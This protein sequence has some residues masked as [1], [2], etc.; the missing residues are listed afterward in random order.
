[1]KK[2]ELRQLI[3][4]E[5]NEIKKGKYELTDIKKVW[6]QLNIGTREAFHLA[7]DLKNPKMAAIVK[8]INMKTDQLHGY[9]VS[10]YKEFMK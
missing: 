1:M 8:Q 2:S 5:I 7:K 9:L 3:K 10:N 6:D 4:E